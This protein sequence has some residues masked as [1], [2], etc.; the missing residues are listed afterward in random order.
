[1]QDAVAAND[2]SKLGWM[3]MKNGEIGDI[4]VNDAAPGTPLSTMYDRMDGYA[5]QKIWSQVDQTNEIK[6]KVEG[7]V[8]PLPKPAK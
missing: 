4:E 6:A 8:L 3:D 1:V 7:P 5:V 2:N